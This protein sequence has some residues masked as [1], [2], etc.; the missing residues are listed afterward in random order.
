MTLLVFLGVLV[1]LLILRSIP[2]LLSRLALAVPRERL[3][4]TMRWIHARKVGIVL[5]R[6]SATALSGA[7][8][9]GS[10]TGSA[11]AG[12]RFRLVLVS[13]SLL[14]LAVLAT[15]AVWTWHS[16]ALMMLLH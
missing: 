2:D 16:S 9:M 13:S 10:A 15:T 8:N 5:P 3:I 4:A 7:F 1:S 11:P 12:G 14:V 6:T